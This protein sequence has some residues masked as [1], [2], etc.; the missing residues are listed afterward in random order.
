MG[1]GVPKVIV[2]ELGSNQKFDEVRRAGIVIT[3]HGSAHF[4]AEEIRDARRA[5]GR[6][7]NM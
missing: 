2:I 1:P 4:I 6:S 7:V 5:A 3:A